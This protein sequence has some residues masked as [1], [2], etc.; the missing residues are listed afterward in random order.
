MARHRHCR[1]G[2]L[3]TLAGVAAST[4]LVYP[5]KTVAPVVSLGVVYLPAILLVSTVWGLRHGPARLRRQRRRLQLLPDPAAAPLHD[6]R[7]G[8]L[9]CAGRVRDR[10]DR[11]QH[12][13]RARPRPRGR[14]GAASRGGRPGAGR[15]GGPDPRARPDA[16]GG[17][18]GRGAAPQRRAEDG[19]AALHLPRPADAADLDH[20]RR[21]RARLGDPDRGGARR[22]E[23]G[24]RRR[25]GAA[26]AP[27]R[28]PA[29]HV[30]AGG[31]EGRAAPGAGRSRRGAGGGARGPRA[32]RSSVRLALDAD[33]PMVDADAAQL[34]RAF[35]NLLEN[36]IRYG[37]G[38]RCWS[39]RGWSA[40]DIVVRVVDQGRGYPRASGSGSSSRSSAAARPPAS[41]LRP[42]PG[43]REGLRRGQR[44]RD[45][46]R[47]AARP[48]HQ[49][50]RH[51]CRRTTEDGR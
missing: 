22:A 16:G 11:Q 39:A 29:R 6:R 13:R 19:A 21:L 46:G 9:G 26:L 44:R 15:A 47:V 3:A 35:A 8:E 24:D 34:E 7:R 33:L 14:G 25:R 23:R 50:R 51:A 43:D 48:G 1:P 41:R 17:G 32:T 38:G 36:A 18:R 5:L 12:R 28:E 4:L 27:G 49:L 40:A 2:L 20:R 42:R 45:R 10:G 30:A 31:G 37:N